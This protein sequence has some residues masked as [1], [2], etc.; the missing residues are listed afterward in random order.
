MWTKK[1]APRSRSRLRII[2]FLLQVCSDQVPTGLV[3]WASWICVC[4]IAR[5]ARILYKICTRSTPELTAD[6]L[7]TYISKLNTRQRKIK[8]Q[9]ININ[10]V[11]WTFKREK[12]VELQNGGVTLCY[13]KCSTQKFNKKKVSLN[14]TLNFKVKIKFSF[15]LV[16][17]F[18]V[19]VF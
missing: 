7:I 8:N 18:S 17:C 14:F 2:C 10:L 16:F 13:K 3:V 19:S 1:R 6:Y 4:R 5:G 15:F 12:T 9:H 11:N